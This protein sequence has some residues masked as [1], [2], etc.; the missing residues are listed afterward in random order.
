MRLAQRHHARGRQQSQRGHAR[1]RVRHADGKL[2]ALLLRHRL[3]K[4]GMEAAPAA[5]A[6][7]AMG[8]VKS[9][10]A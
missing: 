2:V 8:A 10:L 1:D 7:M 3:A 4:N 5:C 6:S 9:C